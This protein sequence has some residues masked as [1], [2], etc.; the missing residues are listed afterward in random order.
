MTD[1]IADWLDQLPLPACDEE[2]VGI[3]R[4]NGY[5]V[6][7]GRQAVEAFAAHYDASLPAAFELLC[8]AKAR[9]RDR[10]SVV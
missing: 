5:T 2:A 4:E 7:T 3:L 6:E 9:A 10:K 8:G 1:W